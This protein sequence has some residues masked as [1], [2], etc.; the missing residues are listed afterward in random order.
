MILEMTSHHLH[1][2]YLDKEEGH[3]IQKSSLLSEH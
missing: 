3:T 2:L 1:L